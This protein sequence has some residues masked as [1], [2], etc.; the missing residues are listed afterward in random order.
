MADNNQY[1]AEIQNRIE[2][3]LSANKDKDAYDLCLQVL[4]KLPDNKDF[5][6]LRDVIEEKIEKGNKILIDKKIAELK[7]LVSEKRYEEILRELNP[8]VK[9]YQTSKLVNFYRDIYSLYAKQ[10][11]V[12]QKDKL[13]ELEMKSDNL[14]NTEQEEGLLQELYKL[15]KNNIGN[16][17]IQELVKKIKTKIIKRKIKEKSDLIYSDKYNAIA[18]FIESLKRIDDHSDDVAKME[19]E[20]RG[21]VEGKQQENKNE[22]IFNG[23][24]YL[25]TLMHL[26]KFDKAVKVAQELLE[27]DENDKFVKSVLKK[28]ESKMFSQ[29]RDS[30]IVSIEESKEYLKR[31]YSKE[32]DKFVKI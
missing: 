5:N 24:N 11:E 9:T 14:I 10:I 16:Y 2:A 22:F 15:E 26:K 20:V 29:T 13:A 28:A 27:V 12:N 31:E 25:Q 6:K 4:K 21:R 30:S 23:K 1:L 18:N 8:F 7:P 19:K 32:K 17:K 3:M